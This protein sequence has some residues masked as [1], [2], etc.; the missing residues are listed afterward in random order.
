MSW[1]EC[2]EAK[3]ESAE[4][5][6]QRTAVE[7]V[8]RPRTRD[9]GGFEVR[10]ALPS[11]KRPMVGPF[12][13]FDQM[14][15]STFESGRG[16]DVRP[17]PHIGLATVTYL[18]EGEIMHR[19]SLGTE[20]VIRP[21]DVNWMK[22][23]RGIVHSERTPAGMRAGGHRL[24]GIQAWVALPLTEEQAE[25]DFIHYPKSSLPNFE[26]EGASIC[27]IAGS[28]F[29]RQSPVAVDWPTI[30]ADIRLAADAVLPVDTEYEERAVYIV[31][32]ELGLEGTTHAAGS[33]LI[34][35]PGADAKITAQGE[36][37]LMLLGG[38]KM[39]GP[40]H[41]WW[42]FVASDMTL[43]EQAKA[44]WQADRFD[45]VPGEHERIPLPEK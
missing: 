32:G 18:F 28:L 39:D 4:S 43:M 21:G 5:Q 16:I 42:N 8:I 45:A 22:A 24:S 10:R 14:G 38:R 7:L 30:Y 31:D 27:L 9:L 1:N 3:T 34:L 19:D 25:P 44:D 26:H 11:G 35:K 40:R 36:C 23:G 12:I 29:G 15:P 33:M 37:H 41:I 2:P 13:F 17:H 20:L 6:A